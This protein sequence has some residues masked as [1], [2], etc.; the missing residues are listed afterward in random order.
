[1]YERR[2]ESNGV[3]LVL[4]IDTASVSVLEGSF[5]GVE[6]ATLSLLGAK[7]EGKEEEEEKAAERDVLRTISFIR[8]NLQHSIFA[9]GFPTRTLSVK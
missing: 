6:R 5:S 4:S 3:R 7:S 2:E 9:S 1:M 8:A